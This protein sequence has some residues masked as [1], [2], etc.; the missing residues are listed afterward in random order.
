VCVVCAVL[1]IM[2]VRGVC[3]VRYYVCAWCV[4]CVHLRVCACVCACACVAAA[5]CDNHPNWKSRIV[6]NVR[7]FVCACVCV[8]ACVCVC[9]C[10][11]VF[12]RVCVWP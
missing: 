5:L 11:C 12:E 7:S 8:R 9:M 4:Q 10:V 6:C 3:S 2:C 1:S